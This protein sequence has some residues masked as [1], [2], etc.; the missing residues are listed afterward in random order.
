[1]NQPLSGDTLLA[2]VRDAELRRC[3]SHCASAQTETDRD[4]ALRGLISV[5]ASAPLALWLRTAVE[6]ANTGLVIGA[7]ALLREIL[8][9]WPD[10]ADARRALVEILWRSGDVAGAEGLLEDNDLATRDAPLAL[11]LARVRRNQGRFEGAAAA[12]HAAGD[13]VWSDDLL[14]DALQFLKQCQHEAQAL[15]WCERELR[16]GRG[17]ARLHATAGNL[18]MA[19]GQFDRARAHFQ[20]ALARSIDLNTWYVPQALAH[21]QRYVDANHLDRELF[22]KLRETPGLDARARASLDFAL[23]KLKEESG[24][25]AGAAQEFRSANSLL[26]STTPWSREAWLRQIDERQAQ[27]FDVAQALSPTDFRPLFV[28][29]LPR[30]GTTLVAERL[31]RHAQVRSRGEPP[32]L[33]FIARQ[34]ATLGAR[35]DRTALQQAAQMYMSQ[36]RQDDSAAPWY[37]D[38]DPLNFRYLDVVAKLFPQARVVYCR[39]QAR[40][41]AVSIWT[42]YFA[43][44]DYAFSS[45]FSDIRVVHDS[46]AALMRHWQASLPLPVLTLDYERLVDDTDAVDAELTQFLDLPT[47]VD[48]AAA[49][50]RAGSISSASLWQ[51]RQPVYR[52]SLGRGERF[53]EFLP[54]LRAAFP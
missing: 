22:S 35:V 45:D 31:A 38:K 14:L 20:N 15:E 24:D 52:H 43:H 21:C 54:E 37:L 8:Q 36:M 34:F 11:Q 25:I 13:A 5:L 18:T 48:D 50:P 46:A 10:S 19:L 1:L 41:T 2:T 30:T 3:I 42:Q 47:L 23:A 32:L 17:D 39:R 26:R 40:D 6:M 12:L 44:P 49:A 33:Q 29:G 28:V 9:R 4:T 16:R 51:A 7:T 53:A 27:I